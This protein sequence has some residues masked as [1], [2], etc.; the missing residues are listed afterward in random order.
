MSGH[1]QYSR[2]KVSCDLFSGSPAS[3]KRSKLEDEISELE[4]ELTSIAAGLE[5]RGLEPSQRAKLQDSYADITLALEA[6]I[7]EWQGD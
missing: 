1:N 5:E 2:S 7:K 3:T 6:L 4:K